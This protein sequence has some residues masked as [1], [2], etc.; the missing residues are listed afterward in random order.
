MERPR[1]AWARQSKAMSLPLARH[2]II[3]LG[4]L[5]LGAWM[6][7]VPAGHVAAATTY[8]VG[9]TS[10]IGIAGTIAECQS[11]ANTTCRLR[12]ALAYA[13]SGTDAITFNGTGRGTITVGSTLT[14]SSGVAII[15]PMSGTGVTVAGGGG[16]GSILFFN[17]GTS[18]IS[19]LTIANGNTRGGGSGSGNGGGI[20]NQG[21]LTV[22]AC[23]LSGNV[24]LLGA[25]GAI[26][27]V[28]GVLTVTDSVFDGNHADFGGGGIDNTGTLR[29]VNSTFANNRTTAGSDGGGIA[30]SASAILTVTN[31]TFSGNSTSFEGGAIFNDGGTVTA[32]NSTL[33]NNSAGTF[34]GGIMNKGT[35]A[36]VTLTNTTV[37]GN[38]AGTG[39]GGISGPDA[40]TL[41]N[42]IVAG[43]TP[44]DINGAQG[45]NSHSIVGGNP[46]LSALGD[47]GGPTQTM[48]PLPGSPAI[49][50]GDPG[51]CASTTAPTG[52]PVGG[53]DQRGVA[54]PA[55]LC[56]IG[57][58]EPLL[59]AIS[60]PSGSIAGGATVTLTGAGFAAGATVSVGNIPCTNVVIVN[61]TTL[62]CTTGMHGAGTVDV[63]VTVG[64][65]TGTLIGGYT[66][67]VVAPLPP[68]QP[69]GMGG[70]PSSPLP[71][72]RPP[73]TTGGNAPSPLPQ[74]RP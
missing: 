32:T 54:R 3:P 71:P 41:T 69:P 36:T 7:T 59:S 25:G 63:V 23:I 37:S 18:S 30:N 6:C 49:G 73:G 13:S 68:G 58:F 35:G 27:N 74:P 28:G 9:S 11:A 8:T 20:F 64:S 24:A 2:R 26:E 42:T 38:T 17:P 51:V 57:A 47:H 67:G 45:A 31:S 16:N 66:Y 21:T 52:A 15:G 10:D 43:N 40:L 14:V 60:P 12:D 39:G 22:T 55:T 44:F 29:V 53:K 4:F 65:Q 48:V 5:L 34:G 19:N 56:A 62:R 46:L 33:A 72:P 1:R 70:G 61:S 50:T